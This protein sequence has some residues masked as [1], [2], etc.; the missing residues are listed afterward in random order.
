MIYQVGQGWPVADRVIPPGTIIDTD[1]F[2]DWSV[3]AKGKPPPIDA[4]AM[5]FEAYDLMMRH[6]PEDKIRTGPD[7]IRK[8]DWP[9]LR[10]RYEAEQRNLRTGPNEVQPTEIKPF[11]KGVK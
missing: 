9:K 2:D 1:K 6:Y 3:L 5:D 7:I 11:N 4:V 10:E 8:A